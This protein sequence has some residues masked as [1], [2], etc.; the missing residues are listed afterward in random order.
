MDERTTRGWMKQG[1]EKSRAVSWA[2]CSG[3]VRGTGRGHASHH[4]HST[5]DAG[6][7]TRRA[8]RTTSRLAGGLHVGAAA[9]DVRPELAPAV[10]RHQHVVLDADAAEVGMAFEHG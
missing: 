7:T 2:A 4:T 9:R 8:A 10:G 5:G 3:R 1:Q 6:T